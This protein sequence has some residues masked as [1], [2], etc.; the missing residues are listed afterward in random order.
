MTMAIAEL[1]VLGLSWGFAWDIHAASPSRKMCAA[2][3][4]GFLLGFSYPEPAPKPAPMAG[5]MAH[6]LAH[7][8]LSDGPPRG[9]LRQFTLPLRG[10]GG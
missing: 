8:G 5:E 3:A 7:L 4:I 6:E 1:F 2:L 9:G 10:E